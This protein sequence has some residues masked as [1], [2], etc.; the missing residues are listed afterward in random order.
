MIFIFFYHAL[1]KEP[2]DSF[3]SLVVKLR[4]NEF[5]SELVALLG[6]KPTFPHSLY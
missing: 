6:R 5:I 4:A 3:G 1:Y 2:K